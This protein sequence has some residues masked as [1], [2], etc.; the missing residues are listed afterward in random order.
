VQQEP[1]VEVELKLRVPLDR[2]DEVE[3]QLRAPGAAPSATD[4]DLDAVYHDTDDWQLSRAGFAW[5]M[6][7][8]GDRWVQALKSRIG[9][10]DTSRF[11]HEVDMGESG[12]STPPPMNASLHAT[13]EIGSRFVATIARLA[14]DGVAPGPQFRVLVHR[15][16]RRVD[17]EFGTVA[18]ALDRG[19][20]I[21]GGT[22]SPTASLDVCEVEFELVTGSVEA[23][24]VEAA[25]WASR[26]ELVADLPNKARRGRAIADAVR[27][28]RHGVG[29][30]PGDR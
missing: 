14:A 6:R 23:V 26:H 24:R 17:T 29:A 19:S 5:R 20:I 30:P 8:E 4:I 12:D 15:V 2:V 22:G 9:G 18:V 28:P 1:H 10:D 13:S 11:E 3:A 27:A 16:E 21:A 25:R 7:R